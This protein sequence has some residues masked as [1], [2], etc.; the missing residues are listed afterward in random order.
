M[1]ADEDA[2]ALRQYV[3][4]LVASNQA[5]HHDAQ[6]QARSALALARQVRVSVADERPAPGDSRPAAVEEL[7]ARRRRLA[8]AIA[9]PEETD[10]IDL[11]DLTLAVAAAATVTGEGDDRGR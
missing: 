3:G 5:V 6:V 11:A 10:A 2:D 9:R 4:A 8:A 1:S 7:D